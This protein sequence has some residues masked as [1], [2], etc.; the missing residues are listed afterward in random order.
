MTDDHTTLFPLARVLRHSRLFSPRVRLTVIADMTGDEARQI[1]WI[2]P[3]DGLCR[4]ASS[5]IKSMIA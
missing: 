3:D 5:L 1:G 2:V 4:A